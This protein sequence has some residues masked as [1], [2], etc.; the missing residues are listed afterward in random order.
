MSADCAGAGIEE[1][2]SFYILLTVYPGTIPAKN[3]LDALPLVYLFI[4][5]L[6]VF[7]TA[8]CS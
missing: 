1:L 5:P 3:Q 8:Q 6:Y 4:L 2:I 7:R